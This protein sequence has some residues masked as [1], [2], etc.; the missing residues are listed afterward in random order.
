MLPLL[1]PI[2]ENIIGYVWSKTRPQS[3]SQS[4]TKE[5][6]MGVCH[7]RP[8]IR[9]KFS[10]IGQSKKVCVCACKWSSTR[11]H[12]LGNIIR[13][14]HPITL[15]SGP[16]SVPG[17][18]ICGTIPIRLPCRLCWWFSTHPFPCPSSSGNKTRFRFKQ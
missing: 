14:P 1:C 13:C 15:I 2:A 12:R 5:V 8:K 7:V 10:G 9:S 16:S 17:K 11:I 18:R 4:A 6:G 3:V